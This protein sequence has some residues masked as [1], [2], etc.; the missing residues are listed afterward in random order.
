MPHG[1]DIFSN[2]SKFMASEASEI[3]KQNGLLPDN[4]DYLIPHQANARIISRVAK[5]LGMDKEKVISNIEETGNTGGAST[6]I[7]LSQSWEMFRKN[8]LV[9]LTV[10]GGGYSSGAMLLRK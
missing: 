9:V 4:I 10:F 1:H 2:A 8:D 5:M 7:C 3:L 6:V